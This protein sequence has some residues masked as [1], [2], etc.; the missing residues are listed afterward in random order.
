M[1]NSQQLPMRSDKVQRGGEVTSF[2]Q[3]SMRV[4]EGLRLQWRNA[5]LL[6]VSTFCVNACP[7]CPD[8]IQLECFRCTLCCDRP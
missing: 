7:L 3:L 6:P 5:F 4:H 8:V 2:L 1:T